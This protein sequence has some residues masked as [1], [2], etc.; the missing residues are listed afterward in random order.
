MDINILVGGDYAQKMNVIISSGESM[1]LPLLITTL[2]ATQECLCWLVG[3]QE[4]EERRFKALDQH[5]GTLAADLCCSVAAD[6]HLLKTLCFQRTT[7]WKTMVSTFQTSKTIYS[8]ARGSWKPS[9]EKDQTLFHL[10]WTRATVD[11]PDDFDY[12]AVDGLPFVVDEWT[13]RLLTVTSFLVM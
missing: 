12:V 10:Q 8:W 5:Q 1:I 4:E 11:L 2:S 13:L 3:V 7:S 6:V 9:K